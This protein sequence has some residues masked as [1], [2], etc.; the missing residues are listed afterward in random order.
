MVALLKEKSVTGGKKCPAQVVSSEGKK[1]PA[2]VS[3]NG[4]NVAKSALVGKHNAAAVSVSVKNT[5]AL[6][7]SD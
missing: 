1:A 4:K 2:L 3:L 6:V 7:V 5:S